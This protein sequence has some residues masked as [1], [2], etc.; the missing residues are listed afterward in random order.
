MKAPR[1]L[2]SLLAYLASCSRAMWSASLMAEHKLVCL[3][4]NGCVAAA[5]PNNCCCR[6]DAAVLCA[7]DRFCA[8]LLTSFIA[9]WR[10]V[11]T[12]LRKCA[13]RILTVSTG[14]LRCGMH[15]RLI[16]PMTPTLH[17]HVSG[18]EL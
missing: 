2:P 15:Y 12:K 14:C 5:E 13:A 9:V 11:V 6:H 16:S 18:R 7:Q 3:V 10:K 4:S 17:Q 8:P 1:R